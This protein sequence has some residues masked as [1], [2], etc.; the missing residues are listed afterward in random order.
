M[1]YTCCPHDSFSDANVTTD[2]RWLSLLRK[3]SLLPPS[4][5]EPHHSNIDRLLPHHLY[6]RDYEVWR[7]VALNVWILILSCTRLAQAD[8]YCMWCCSICPQS[9][10]LKIVQKQLVKG[11]V[12]I[13]RSTD[14]KDQ[15]WSKSS[16]CAEADLDR[17]PA[18]EELHMIRCTVYGPV[19]SQ[20]LKVLIT[21]C[22]LDISTSK[23]LLSENL[24]QLQ[25][26]SICLTV[27]NMKVPSAL[28]FHYLLSHSTPKDSL[29]N[30]RT[31]AD[32]VSGKLFFARAQQN[33][34]GRPGYRPIG[35]LQQNI[36]AYINQQWR[37]VLKPVIPE[38]L[39]VLLA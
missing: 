9:A 6:Q 31:D 28:P 4:L 1:V 15:R 24:P 29:S 12:L 38:Q 25:T 30:V 17:L 33:H 35:G 7:H 26:L 22:K 14:E 19:I 18:L 32:F 13:L 11:P 20:S 23:H 36:S 8:L 5:Y 39:L 3:N 27:N 10:M 37:L 16:A 21:E 34:I 2:A